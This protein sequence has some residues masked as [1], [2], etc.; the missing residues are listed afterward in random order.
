[1]RRFWLSLVMLA[2][3]GALMVAAQLAGASPARQGG[4]FVVGTTGASV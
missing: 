1:M 4:V 2:V 3:G